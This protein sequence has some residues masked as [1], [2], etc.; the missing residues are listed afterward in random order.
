MSVPFARKLRL[1]VQ[2]WWC[3]CV[4]RGPATAAPDSRRPG[5]S[6]RR[7]EA[8]SLSPRLPLASFSPAD[9]DAS[10]E[11]EGPGGRQPG[12]DPH[13]QGRVRARAVGA[14]G[15]PLRALRH[16]SD[17]LLV[18][19]AWGPSCARATGRRPRA[20]TRWASSQ[21]HR[22]GRLA[23]LARHR[24]S[25]PARPGPW[26]APAPTSWCTAAARSIGCYAMTN[27]VM[28][29]IYALSERAL[30][31]GQERIPVHVFPFRM[32][33]ANL[34][35]ARGERWHGFWLNLKEAY[36]VFERTRIPPTVRVCRRPLRRRPGH[37]IRRRRRGAGRR[38]G[39]LAA[40]ATR[41]RRRSHN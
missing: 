28:E 34:A 12:D 14:E 2:A 1:S 39:Y 25:Q 17:L 41:T 24:L 33:E 8:P 32:T 11:R 38:A 22:K 18:R 23:A 10:A 19:G 3:C 21:L 36:D 9:R 20:S 29:E 31:E 40:V 5:W 16:L 30:R 13:L 27:P 4:A 35:G 37:R 26:P 7:E 6:R 15:R